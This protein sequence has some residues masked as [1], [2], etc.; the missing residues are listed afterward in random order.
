LRPGDNLSIEVEVDPTFSDD[1]FIIEWVVTSNNPSST[2][3]GKKLALRIEN[4]HVREDF[5]IYCNVTS[6]KSWHRLGDCDE[7]LSL[8]YRVLPPIE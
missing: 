4:S 5:T 6:N 3:K 8:T 2:F 1:Q 7:R